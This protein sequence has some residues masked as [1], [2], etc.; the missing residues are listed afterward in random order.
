MLRGI[1][2]AAIFSLQSLPAE[3]V[4]LTWRAEV[5]ED[6][7]FEMSEDFFG[8]RFTGKHSDYQVGDTFYPTWASDDGRKMW[9]SYSANFANEKNGLGLEPLTINPPGGRYGLSLHEMELI[10]QGQ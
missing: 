5:P 7:P 10:P 3:E 4:Q 6:C 9:L 8:V 1:L 2:L